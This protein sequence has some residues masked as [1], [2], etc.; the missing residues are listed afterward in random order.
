MGRKIDQE[1]GQIAY[2]AYRRHTNGVS[3][4]TG[5]NIPPWDLLPVEIKDAWVAAGRA[6]EDRVTD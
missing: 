4:A 6:V 1:V 2:E 5:D 3:L